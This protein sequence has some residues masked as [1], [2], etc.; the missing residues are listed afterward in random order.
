MLKRNQKNRALH[1]EIVMIDKDTD[2]EIAIFR[3]A[4]HA[5]QFLKNNGFPRANHWPI[6]KCCLG[7]QKT[8]YSHKWKFKNETT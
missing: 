2:K 6:T 8:A 1:G 4:T 5:E 7:K 3:C